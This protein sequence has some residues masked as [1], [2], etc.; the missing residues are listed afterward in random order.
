MSRSEQILTDCC[1]SCSNRE[2]HRA[3]FTKDYKLLKKCI[4]ARSV[5]S[6]INDAWGP[7]CNDTPISIAFMMGDLKALEFILKPNLG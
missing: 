5:I 6:S 4:E 2:V 7:D 1:I 3:V